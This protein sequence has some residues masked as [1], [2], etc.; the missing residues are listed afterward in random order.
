MEEKEK[1]KS[2]KEKITR[3]FDLIRAEQKQ[4]ITP[5]KTKT[6]VYVLIKTTPANVDKGAQTNQ[7]DLKQALPL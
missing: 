3:Y 1:A 4:T 7:D 5:Q 6:L 2:K